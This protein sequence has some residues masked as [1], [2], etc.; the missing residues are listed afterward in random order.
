M[1]YGRNEAGEPITVDVSSWIEV[2][3]D[4]GRVKREEVLLYPRKRKELLEFVCDRYNA[5]ALPGKRLVNISIWELR[6]DGAQTLQKSLEGHRVRN[7]H[8]EDF[9]CGVGLHLL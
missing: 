4:F 6:W 9:T 2:P 1:A 5:S 7:F 3:V 8:L